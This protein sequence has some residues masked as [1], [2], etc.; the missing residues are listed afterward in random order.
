MS[1]GAGVTVWYNVQAPRPSA[2]LPIPIRLPGRGFTLWTRAA[3]P[4]EGTA[5]ALNPS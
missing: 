1:Q 5:A 3:T 4:I 2:S